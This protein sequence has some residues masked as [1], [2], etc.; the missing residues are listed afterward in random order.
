MEPNM[1]IMKRVSNLIIIV[2]S[3]AM[4]ACVAQEQS[5]TAA[6][7]NS[8]GNTQKWIVA[9]E[10]AGGFAGWMKYISTDSAGVVIIRDLKRNKITKNKLNNNELTAL[11]NLIQQHKRTK[12]DPATPDFINNCKDCFTYKLSIRSHNQQRLESSNDLNLSKSK[13]HN[14]VLFLKEILVKYEKK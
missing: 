4:S 9:L 14:I 1:L 7:A 12:I 2:I 11:S 3:I 10:I 5:E 6:T 8:A 13:F